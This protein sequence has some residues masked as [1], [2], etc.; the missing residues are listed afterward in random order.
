MYFEEIKCGTSFLGSSVGGLEDTFVELQMEHLN[1]CAL[2]G[3]VKS[4]AQQLHLPTVVS[5]DEAVG[6]AVT[7]RLALSP[8]LWL[9]EL[10]AF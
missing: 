7:I 4:A 10:A 9:S 3:Y 8:G 1:F 5:S 6:G 2:L